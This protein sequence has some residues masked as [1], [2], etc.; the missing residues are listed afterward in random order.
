MILSGADQLAFDIG[1]R[2]FISALGGGAFAWPFAARAQQDDQVRRIGVLDGVDDS[3]GRT[4]RAAFQAALRE[5][6]WTDGHNVRFDYRWGEGDISRIQAYAA[7]LV[8]LKPDVILVE[9]LPSVE[10]LLRETR[11]VPIVMSNGSDP[12][13]AG[14]VSNLARPGGNFTGFI[15]FEFALAGKWLE[16]L[17]EIAPKLLRVTIIFNPENPTWRGQLRAIEIAAPAAGVQLHLAGVHDAAEIGRAID[18]IDGGPN[19]GLMIMPVV[20][21]SVNREL[22]IALAA[23]HHAPA[24]YPYAY[25]VRS[26]GLLS[27]GIDVTDLYRR[28][29]SYVD[30]ILKGEKVGDLP[31]QN[32]TKYELAINLNTAKALGLAVPPAVLARADEVIE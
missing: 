5:L 16:A 17:K 30:R 15:N 18:G 29:A 4:R 13:V 12:V 28:A 27:Y 21:N 32:P 19:D 9:G 10:A 26:G 20:V 14:F 23:K 31:V 25:F 6:G 3:E 2:R 7:E 11:T 1:R 24:V 22:I 8:S